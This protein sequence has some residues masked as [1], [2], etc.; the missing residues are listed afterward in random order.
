MLLE[1]DFH[2]PPYSK[3]STWARKIFDIGKKPFH[4]TCLHY[5]PLRV[6]GHVLVITVEPS[7]DWP[8]SDSEFLPVPTWIAAILALDTSEGRS[9]V[10]AGSKARL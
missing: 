2:F 4:E 5:L 1:S 7:P 6:F 9:Y 10:R 8:A 3:L